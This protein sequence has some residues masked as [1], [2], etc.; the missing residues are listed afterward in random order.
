MT[1]LYGSRCSTGVRVF[2]A[3]DSDPKSERVGVR[4]RRTC[5]PLVATAQRRQ[6]Q[7]SSE[8]G[9]LQCTKV[10]RCT[11]AIERS[12]SE[13]TSSIEEPAESDLHDGVALSLSRSHPR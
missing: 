5:S 10:S 6:E 13:Q 12:A 11:Q 4:T 3:A 8:H 2:L 1:L 7:G 9:D